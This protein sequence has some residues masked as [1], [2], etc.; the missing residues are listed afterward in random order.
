MKTKEKASATPTEIAAVISEKAQLEINE[1]Q[2][3]IADL[4]SE[5]EHLST[6]RQQIL[7]HQSQRQDRLIDIRKGVRDMEKQH[8]EAV[9]YAS[10]A[11]DTIAE[12]SAVKKVTEILAQLEPARAHVQSIEVEYAALGNTATSRLIEIDTALQQIASELQ[13]KQARLHDVQR[14]RDVSVRELGQ[15]TYDGLM[16]EYQAYQQ[17]ID[18]LKQQITEVQ[19]ARQQFTDQAHATLAA[20]PILQREITLLQP[21][22]DSTSRVLNAAITYLETLL[23]DGPHT[24]DSLKHLPAGYPFQ[25]W[26][27]IIAVDADNLYVRNHI[28]GS[29]LVLQEK[30]ATLQALL[31]QYAASKR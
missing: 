17:K 11:Q 3:R 7:T 31:S 14:V 26:L 8:T 22:D 23:Y 13:T 2:A 16:E 27:Q 30:H 10:V 9:A 28:K 29:T 6:E 18:A 25:T 4:L 19:I 15:H 12:Q 1:L 21:Y 24:V 20:W 5:S